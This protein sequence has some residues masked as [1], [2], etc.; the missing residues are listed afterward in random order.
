MYVASS[1]APQNERVQLAPNTPGHMH[2]CFKVD[3]LPAAYEELLAAGVRFISPPV[4]VTAGIN[5]GGYGV[6]AFDPSDNQIEIFQ[7]P[8]AAG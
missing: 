7:P 4:L 3:D 5:A 1:L 6:Y 8:A 2:L